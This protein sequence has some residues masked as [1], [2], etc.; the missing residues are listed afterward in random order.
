MHRSITAGG[1][2]RGPGFLTLAIQPGQPGSAIGEI[3]RN[4]N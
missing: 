4:I 2:P 1:D 3:G